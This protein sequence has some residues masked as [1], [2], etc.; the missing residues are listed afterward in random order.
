MADTSLTDLI[1]QLDTIQH[2]L[3]ARA[4]FLLVYGA[5]SDITAAR[6]NIILQKAEQL[7]G[8]S[9]EIKTQAADLAELE[10]EEQ[11]L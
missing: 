3:S 11:L 8:I 7:K 9:E 5:T 4:D 6:E 1:E 10:L 2:R